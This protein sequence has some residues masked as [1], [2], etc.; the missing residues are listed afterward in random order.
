MRRTATPG[1]VAR[2]EQDL[3][4]HM[5][6]E[7]VVAVIAMLADVV[8]DC[9]ACGEPVRRCDRRRLSENSRLAHLACIP[10]LAR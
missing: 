2:W 10:G 8:G 5:A 3:S 1:E 7:R 4:P 6:R 9:P